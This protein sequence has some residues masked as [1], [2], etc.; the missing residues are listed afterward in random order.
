MRPYPLPCAPGRTTASGVHGPKEL[1]SRDG[2]VPIL[3][4]ATLTNSTDRDRRL[5]L[6][7]CGHDGLRQ[8]DA[9]CTKGGVT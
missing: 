6:V 9:A 1:S 3:T 2:N 5:G 7:H 8:G 4:T